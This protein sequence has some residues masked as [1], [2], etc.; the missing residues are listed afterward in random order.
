[1]VKIAV[2][3]SGLGSFSIIKPI[4][5]K[6]IADIIYFADQ[7]NFPYGKKSV[8]ELEKIIKSTI[9]VLDKSFSPNLIVIGSNTPSLLL[10][11]IINSPRVI[12]VFPPLK[13][14]KRK[15]KTKTIAILATESVIKSNTLQNYI[16][17]NVPKKI[18]VITINA[19]PLVDL[20]ES[21]KFIDNKKLC[22]N[23]IKKILSKPFIKHNVD[24]ATL[25]STHL[26]FLL[27]FLKEVFPN[28]M[29]LDPGSIV[30]DKIA[31]KLKSQNKTRSLTIFASGNVRVFQK[32]LSKIGIKNKVRSL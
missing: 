24:V 25:S 12:G 9:G 17:K 11:K 22:K 14:A 23:K 5:K 19:S 31:K 16:K 30:A 29:F 15:T 3:D 26:P 20:V 6:I 27:P 8:L 28:I 4:Q 10:K 32:K 2:F 7:R 13:D 1:M 21:G 18:K